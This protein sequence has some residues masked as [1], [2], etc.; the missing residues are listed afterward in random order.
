MAGLYIHVPFCK[1]RCSYCAFFS[2]TDLDRRQRYVDA[3]CREIE[4]RSQAGEII[5]GRWGDGSADGLQTVYLGGGTPSQ[6]TPRQL[7]MLFETI[8]RFYGLPMKRDVP[9]EEV[10][11]ECNPDD[12]TDGFTALL[13]S[14]PVNRISMGAQTFSDVRLRFLGRRHKPGQVPEA[15]HRLR[16][17]GIGNISIDLMY[18]FPGETMDEWKYDIDSVLALDVEHVSAYCLS[19]EEGTPLYRQLEQGSVEELDEELCR[20]MYE[21]LIDHLEAA[22][23]CHYEISNFAR[24]GFHSRHN[25]SYWDG[26]PY[27]GIGAA[28]H[29]YDG[30]ARQWNP[31][32]LDSYMEGVESGRRVF[33]R[34]E[35]DDVT[36]YNDRVT[37]ALRTRNGLDL[38]EL[39]PV[40][41]SYCIGQA[42][43]YI[44]SGELRVNTLLTASGHQHTL[45]S[46]TRE[47][48]F[49]S[50]M[51][52]SE[53]MMV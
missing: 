24:P 1:S 43:R 40:F 7:T 50:D 25:S 51:V 42:Q 6:L 36:R 39:N 4:E 18:G 44:K 20:G 32:N 46:L 41:R 37:V 38:D 9:A 2:T 52:M 17:A 27:L 14:L 11:I 29:S 30:Y 16:E 21:T 47:G 19:Y 34:E 45:L 28:A 35:L 26:T 23:F 22:G 12:V 49:V 53:L 8:G 10:T 15:V 5:R 33:E 48:L 31:C 3:L 13:S